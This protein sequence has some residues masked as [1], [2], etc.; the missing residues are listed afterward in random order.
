M[1]I[2]FPE[3][4]IMVLSFFIIWPI[5]QTGF[6]M[7]CN[8]IPDSSFDTNSW[9]YRTHNWEKGG[10][11]YDRVFKIRLW[12]HLLPDGAA[13]FDAGF[14][15]KTLQSIDE[16]YLEGFIKETCRAELAH[17]LQIAPFW[18]FALWSPFF[19]IWIMLTYALLVN[20]PCIIAQRYNRP[21]IMALKVEIDKKKMP[22]PQ[23]TQPGF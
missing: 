4:W 12:K 9:L 14:K 11:I 2:F 5:V 23:S 1:Q 6:S 13:V 21:R 17:W 20:M 15:K 22:T 8:K 7:L 18:V 3:K 19:V 10:R 16:K